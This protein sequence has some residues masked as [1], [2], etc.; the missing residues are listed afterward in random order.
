M[1]YKYE[2]ASADDG[3]P[4]IKLQK[5]LCILEQFLESE[6]IS[7]YSGKTVIAKLDEVISQKENQL[8]W[9]GNI[10][11]LDVKKGITR[12]FNH[13]LDD[14]VEKGVQVDEEYE[15]FIESVELR[16]LLYVWVDEIDKYRT[17]HS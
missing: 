8:L 14:D 2:I 3:R 16:D 6:I 1:K 7:Q 9:W 11:A 12:V 17:F 13:Y 5:E 4:V 10:Y 15:S